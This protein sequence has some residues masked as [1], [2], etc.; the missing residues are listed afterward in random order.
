MNTLFKNIFVAAGMLSLIVTVG[1]K[2]QLD[3]NQ[4]PNNPAVD[5]GTPTLVL[6]AAIMGTTAAVGGELAILGSI[7]GEYTT[8]AAASNQYKIIS[9][10]QLSSTNLNGSYRLLFA[11]GLKNYQFI[12]DKSKAS[13]NWNFYLMAATMKAYTAQ[14][15][16]DLYDKVPYSEALQGTGNLNP[17]FDDGYTIY[18]DLLKLLDTALV[19]PVNGA[20]LTPADKAADLVF[21]GDMDKWRRFANTL[22]MKMYLRMANKKPAEAEAGINKLYDGG[23]TFLTS[24]AAVTGFTDVASKSNP[25]YEQNIRQLNTPANIRASFTFVS[26]LQEAND[27][28]LTYHFN[29]QTPNY[30]HQ[31]DYT[32]T[33]NVSLT[34]ATLVQKATDPVIFIS[35]AES[36]FMQAESLER[37]YAGLGAKDKYDAGVLAAF[38]ATGGNGAGF[39][40]A[41]NAYEYPNA[42]TLAQKLEAINTQ[43]WVSH[44]TGVHFLEGFLNR[45]RTGIPKQSPVYST[46]NTYVPG[47]FVIS[48]NS[49]LLPGLLPQRLVYP[50]SERQTNNN[51]P[52]EVP[53]STPVWWA[54]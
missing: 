23:A 39:I 12:L 48:K 33:D 54:L 9:A 50:N 26:F 41:G 5:N 36:N 22:E 4:D 30:I 13:E 31:G 47:Q 38:A 53:L 45:N 24:N 18:V 43:A 2:K 16:V 34:A 28:R 3:I 25:M 6:P 49:V 29:S 14:V 44:A 21:G 17:K 52:T 46:D 7:W 40:G 42:G 37:Y 35:L 19:K 11:N 1:C 10:Y 51:T 27:T 32:A 20:T 8:Q 15:L